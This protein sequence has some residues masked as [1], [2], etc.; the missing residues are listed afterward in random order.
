MQWDRRDFQKFCQALDLFPREDFES[1]SGHVG[2]KTSEQIQE[3]SSRFFENMSMLTD[4]EK[5]T[6]NIEKAEKG[7]SFKRQAPNLIRQ[8]VTAYERPVEEMI[9]AVA[10]KSKYFS[11]ESDIVLLCLTHEHGYGNWTKIKQAIRRDTR[12][13]FDHLF[14]SR[15]ELDL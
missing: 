9:L 11:R 15:S 5:I 4:A 13:R 3:Y 14:M 12:C 10:Q 7:H 6:K 1:I 8:K 2:T